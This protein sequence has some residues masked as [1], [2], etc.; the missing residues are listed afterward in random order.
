MERARLS[1]LDWIEQSSP[2]G[3]FGVWRKN[4]SL[5]AGG[6]KDVGVAGGGHPF[7]VE[8]IRLPA[9][10]TNW[11]L[12]AHAAQWE[13]YLIIAGRGRVRT[14]EGVEAIGAGDFL[15]HPPG[16]AHQMINDGPEDL[17]YY[18]IADNPQ[19]DVIHYPESQKWLA[20]PARKVFREEV[21]Y[22]DGE[23]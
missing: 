22:F 12:H 23:E 7:D 6:K 5:A 21:D 8:L 16:E 10:K 19:A 13:A 20:K 14:E 3:K 11:P 9:G 15:V 2:K 17:V 4:L 18:V 1:D